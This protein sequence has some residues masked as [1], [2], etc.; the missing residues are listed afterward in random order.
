MI[1]YALNHLPPHYVA[2]DRGRLMVKLK[3]YEIQARADVLSAVSEAAV[4]VA[5]SP[6][7]VRE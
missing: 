5:K 6:R 3:S 2:T 1:A 7:H 4:M